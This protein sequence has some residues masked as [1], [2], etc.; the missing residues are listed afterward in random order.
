M[1]PCETIDR[2]YLLLRSSKPQPCATRLHSDDQ[3]NPSSV[4][5]CCTKRSKPTRRKGPSSCRTFS[6][7]FD[8]KSA[9]RVSIN[10][11]GV[12]AKASER[13]RQRD[14][15]DKTWAPRN[16]FRQPWTGHWL[17]RA[18]SFWLNSRG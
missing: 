17:S 18:W 13:A 16:R 14:L 4:K 1:E 5:C 15:Q 10:V 3:P 8:D 2:E 9:F 6:G 11:L 7:S 12:W